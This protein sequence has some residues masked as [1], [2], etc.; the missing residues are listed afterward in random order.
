VGPKNE[1][2]EIR[3]DGTGRGDRRFRDP[4]L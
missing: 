3:R 2:G 4:T 1:A